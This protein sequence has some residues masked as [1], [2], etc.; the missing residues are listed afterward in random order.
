M[1]T[2]FRPLDV[3]QW[4]RLRTSL[5][6][7]G[8][9]GLICNSCQTDHVLVN[10]G[11]HPEGTGLGGRPGSDQMRIPTEGEFLDMLM[12][13]DTPLNN[14]RNLTRNRDWFQ[15]SDFGTA[16]RANSCYR[17][18]DN[19]FPFCT[20]CTRAVQIGKLSLIHI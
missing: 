4:P 7:L 20:Q 19:V 17:V 10:F 9:N 8:C 18:Q 3:R 15:P 1:E 6:C 12:T 5:A 14:C 16:Q 2:N 11:F 13:G